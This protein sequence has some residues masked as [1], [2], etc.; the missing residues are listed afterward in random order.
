MI[1][2]E[3]IEEKVIFL[4]NCID[5]NN[6]CDLNEFNNVVDDIKKI[7]EI[8]NFYVILFEKYAIKNKNK[9]LFSIIIEILINK[10]ILNEEI[11]ENDL[12]FKNILTIFPFLLENLIITKQN[13]E[14]IFKN[15]STLY[16]NNNILNSKILL[17]YLL[18]LEAIF[19]KPEK[20]T[21]IKEPKNFFYFFNESFFEID[22]K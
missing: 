3:K 19:K 12:K 5:K 14:I 11:S 6:N 15:L 16:F 13:V 7:F 21:K 22:L 4:F 1:T 8:E 2:N 17:K 20:K 10:L 18:L 9:N